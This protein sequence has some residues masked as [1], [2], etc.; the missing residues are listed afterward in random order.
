MQHGVYKMKSDAD[1]RMASTGAVRKQLH[2]GLSDFDPRKFLADAEHLQ[3]T[4]CGIRS[5][6][7]HLKNPCYQFG[8]DVDSLCQR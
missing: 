7:E 5:V 2:E 6:R 8:K 4:P 3:G 1:L